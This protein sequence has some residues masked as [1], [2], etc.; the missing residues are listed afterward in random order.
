MIHGIIPYLIEEA[1]ATAYLDKSPEDDDCCEGKAYIASPL[2]DVELLLEHQESSNE[3]YQ[4]QYDGNRMAGSKEYW[5]VTEHQDEVCAPHHYIP[6]HK[7]YH[8]G[9]VRHRTH[10]GS[11]RGRDTKYEV[12]LQP[13]EE[14]ASCPGAEEIHRHHHHP[15]SEGG[16][17]DEIFRSGATNSLQLWTRITLEGFAIDEEIVLCTDAID[18]GGGG[19]YYA[20]AKQVA[21]GSKTLGIV[22]EEKF[23]PSC[24]EEHST[25]DA[26]ECLFGVTLYEDTC[27]SHNESHETHCESCIMQGFWGEGVLHDAHEGV[28]QWHEEKDDEERAYCLADVKLVHITI[29]N[30]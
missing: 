23:H 26:K 12:F 27:D 28:A 10:E 21:M 8:A 7:N 4:S 5:V 25:N 29:G 3:A 16:R 11:S 9:M 24:P 22:E 1:V 14:I 17:H 20:S 2:G 30:G 15:E 6:L 18:I 13:V 19:L